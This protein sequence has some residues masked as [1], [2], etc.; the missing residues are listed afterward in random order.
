MPESLR[1]LSLFVIWGTLPVLPLAARGEEPPAINP[2]GPRPAARADAIPGYLELSSGAIHPGKLY[3]TRDF[4]LK[5]FDEAQKRQREVPLSV[6][7]RIDCKVLKE[8]MEKEWRF[9]ENANNVK[10][11]TGRTYP[12]REYTYTITLRD[13]RTIRGPM[14]GIIYVRQEGSTGA[15]RYLFHKRDKGPVGSD[16]GSLLYVRSVHLG[17]KALEEGRKK[18]A[19]PPEGKR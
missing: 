6:V 2:F 5:I 10:V 18:A 14:S 3:L 12:A 11:Y 19:H 17:E 4:R 16:L 15:D 9:K 13:G 8:W 1:R 7:R